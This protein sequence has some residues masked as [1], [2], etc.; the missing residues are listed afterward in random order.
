MIYYLALRLVGNNFSPP[1]LVCYADRDAVIMA[2]QQ[3][4]VTEG[5][6]RIQTLMNRK[7]HSE[8]V[9]TFNLISQPVTTVEPP[10][11]DTFGTYKE[12]P[13]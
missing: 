1:R 4:R 8:R 7:L 10:N 6:H 13:D 2:E 5:H 11:A 12:R 9:E 3:V